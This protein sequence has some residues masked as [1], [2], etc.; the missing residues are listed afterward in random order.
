MS[1][2]LLKVP[3]NLIFYGQSIEYCKHAETVEPKVSGEIS[4]ARKTFNDGVIYG[5]ITA[6]TMNDPCE[7][8]LQTVD[9][10]FSKKKKNL[11]GK[12]HP[13]HEFFNPAV[14]HIF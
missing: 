12:L 8:V 2:R 10:N 4:E 7:A 1:H 3:F 5:F 14:W 6:S 9:W 11:R 13:T